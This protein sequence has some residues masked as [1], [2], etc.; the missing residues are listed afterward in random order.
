MV[1]H[2]SLSK[3]QRKLSSKL[4]RLPQVASIQSARTL[5]VRINSRGQYLCATCPGGIDISGC[6]KHRLNGIAR[7]MSELP[8]KSAVF[9]LRLSDLANVLR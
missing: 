7:Q 6:L 9:K 3:T 1:T 2:S 5:V 8:L 4:N